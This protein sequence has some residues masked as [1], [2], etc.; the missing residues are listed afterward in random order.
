MLC[1]MMLVVVVRLS[2]SAWVTAALGVD[3]AASR[4][5]VF[6]W[7]H[8]FTREKLIN[9]KNN[10][11]EPRSIL[12]CADR[13]CP[14]RGQLYAIIVSNT[15][16]LPAEYKC[17]GNKTIS[18]YECLLVSVLTTFLRRHKFWLHRQFLLPTSRNEEMGDGFFGATAAGLFEQ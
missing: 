8:Y 18:I 17:L 13:V 14:Y 2:V 3:N 10:W 4:T 11:K 6:R 5:S 16:A 15:H 9:C 1:V 12:I 7:T